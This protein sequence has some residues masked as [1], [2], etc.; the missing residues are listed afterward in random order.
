MPWV[1][2][3]YLHQPDQHLPVVGKPV[4]I[5]A[6]S[7]FNYLANI[8]AGWAPRKS[9]AAVCKSCFLRWL[10]H[11]TG[12]IVSH[13]GVPPKQNLHTIAESICHRKIHRSRA[14]RYTR[15]AKSGFCIF[16]RKAGEIKPINNFRRSS[17][18]T[19]AQS[20]TECP[21]SVPLR[22]CVT[23]LA[24]LTFP[25]GS[26]VCLQPHGEV[27]ESVVVTLFKNS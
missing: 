19:I 14:F 13:F 11:N 2:A 15:I 10:F 25:A 21:K 4:L 22:A 23:M 5:T 6:K 3:Q 9:S 18:P 17:K 8:N 1:G 12:C 26:S 24:C 27:K 16:H 20:R 7:G